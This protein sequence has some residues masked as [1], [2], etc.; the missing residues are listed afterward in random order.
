MCSI[1]FTI[2]GASGQH[3]LAPVRIVPEHSGTLTS[4]LTVADLQ[5]AN[6]LAKNKEL[7][8]LDLSRNSI[9]ENGVEVILSLPIIDF[10]KDKLNMDNTTWKSDAL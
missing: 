5:I 10:C 2:S 3:L 9:S 8:S 4:A 6:A 7:T 1:V